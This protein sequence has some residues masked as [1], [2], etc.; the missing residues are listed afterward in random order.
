MAICRSGIASHGDRP[1]VGDTAGPGSTA[2]C[3]A[4]CGKLCSTYARMRAVPGFAAAAAASCLFGPMHYNSNSRNGSSDARVPPQAPVMPRIHVLVFM[5]AVDGACCTLGQPAY[6]GT[7]FVKNSWGYSFSIATCSDGPCSGPGFNYLATGEA[8]QSPNA[9]S[10]CDSRRY[11][12]PL[13]SFFYNPQVREVLLCCASHS[14][15]MCARL[16]CS[17]CHAL[18][19]SHAVSKQRCCVNFYIVACWA[20][21][22][23]T[24]C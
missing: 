12:G 2:A 3:L 5:Q 22:T 14:S 15:S 17:S 6:S 9:D 11:P 23:Y 8:A 13:N 19:I 7:E 21:K 18:F 20:V 4:A 24:H 1:A 16:H 10:C